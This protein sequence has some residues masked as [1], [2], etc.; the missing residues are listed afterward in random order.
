MLQKGENKGGK[1]IFLQKEYKLIHMG[2]I[3]ELERPFATLNV[4]I[5]SDDDHGCM[6]K[7]LGEELLGKGYLHGSR[8]SHHRSLIN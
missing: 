8:I 5:L 6:I 7:S 2:G 1:N 3:T 4:T